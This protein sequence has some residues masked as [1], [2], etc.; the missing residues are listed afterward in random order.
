[1]SE[2][3]KEKS[4]ATRG[5]K[6]KTRSAPKELLRRGLLDGT[7]K[8]YSQLRDTAQGGQREDTAADRVQDTTERGAR[9]AV[10]RLGRMRLGKKKAKG[11]SSDTPPG[12]TPPSS[13]GAESPAPASERVQI[14]TRDA[15]RDAPT[16]VYG[17]GGQPER[18][19]SDHR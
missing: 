1:M 15:V 6:E 3:V 4:P 12:P 18:P 5:I 13:D 17:A 16:K 7:E 9:L 8:L 14:K 2:K 10:D 11:Q 19:T